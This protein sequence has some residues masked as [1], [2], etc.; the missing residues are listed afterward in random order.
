MRIDKMNLEIA[1]S[2]KSLNFTKLA[3][4]SKVSRATLSYINNGKSCRP[5]IVKRIAT[6]LGVDV[7]DLIE[8]EA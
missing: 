4:K 5:E 7:S 1:M 6:A 3:E 2:E 8:K